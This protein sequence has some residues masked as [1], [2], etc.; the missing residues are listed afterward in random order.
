MRPLTCHGGQISLCHAKIEKISKKICHDQ[1]R[2]GGGG[3]FLHFMGDT[4][5]MRGDIELMGVPQSP[6]TRENTGGMRETHTIYTWVADSIR[7]FTSQ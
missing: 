1:Q 6:L 5:V 4:A 3:E 2:W 7:D